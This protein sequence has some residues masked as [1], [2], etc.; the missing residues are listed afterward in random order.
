M[1]AEATNENNHG[2]DGNIAGVSKTPAAQSVPSHENIALIKPLSFPDK[3]HAIL[4]RLDLADIISWMPHGRSWRIHK[5]KAFESRVIPLFFVQCKY[6][7]FIRQANGWGF[8]RITKGPDR[9]SY[10]NRYFLRGRQSLSRR[11]RR[12]ATSV[13]VPIRP[14]EEP[15]LYQMSRDDPL[16]EIGVPRAKTTSS[17]SVAPPVPTGESEP[18]PASKKNQKNKKPNETSSANII[19]SSSMDR[20]DPMQQCP[21]IVHTNL[22][23]P[24]SKQQHITPH[25]QYSA[26]ES[27]L[28]F[29]SQAAAAKEAAWSQSLEA[30]SL[31][32][33]SIQL[34]LSSLQNSGCVLQDQRIGIGGLPPLQMLNFLYPSSGPE[35]QTHN[36][37]LLEWPLSLVSCPIM[38]AYHFRTCAGRQATL[39]STTEGLI[40]SQDTQM[41]AIE[42][43]ATRPRFAGRC[44]P[45]LG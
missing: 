23:P 21:Q 44:S 40:T 27:L 7:S 38:A 45:L 31:K 15:D 29:R 26:A 10:Y 43:L 34:K 32:K 19:W 1:Q 41:Q 4:S 42:M 6:S 37:A 30:A 3:L 18:L 28:S 8:Q 11:M 5:P 12:P 24:T 35:I 39:L 13:K 36:A 14:G 33:R 25:H 20:T 2:Q 17:I 9:N 16:P 22:S